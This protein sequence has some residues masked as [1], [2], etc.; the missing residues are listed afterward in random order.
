MRED[1]ADEVYY[2]IPPD[3]ER[4]NMSPKELAKILFECDKDSPKY[5]LVEHELNLRIA[6]TQARA[7]L[8]ASVISG[9]VG[10]IAGSIF[11]LIVG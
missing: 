8:I 11:A 4:R 1:I 3:N 2:G 9:L 10:A 5:I 6:N 7:T